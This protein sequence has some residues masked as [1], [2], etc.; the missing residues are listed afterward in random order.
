M[1]LQK[2]R[3][4][5]KGDTIGVVATGRWLNPDRLDQATHFWETRG[6]RVKI[7]PNNYS[8][9]HEW[10]GDFE[11]RATALAD[12]LCDPEI[13]AIF[14][15]G[16]GNRTLHLLDYINFERLKNTP[17]KIIMGFSD[18]TALINAL[19]HKCHWVTFH[20]PSIAGYSKDTAEIH[21]KEVTEILSG[22]SVSHN[23]TH[24]QTLRQG[25]G[26]GPLI[27]G[28]MCIFTYLLGT[29]FISDLKGKILF[30]EDES[31]EIRNIDRMLLH[32]RRLGHMESISGLMI[33]GFSMIG[34]NGSISFPYSLEELLLEHT[35][36]LNI[37]VIMN[38]PFSHS[39]DII[40]L[41]LGIEA[42]LTAGAETSTLK[43]LESAVQ[44]I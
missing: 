32:L 36:G 15:A 42:A 33:G 27:G 28:N 3:A 34:N 35:E 39:K 9:Y 41:P 2:P 17:P 43:L 31:E 13:T 7:H 38:A 6:Y 18:T 44:K 10:G 22:D 37:P 40:P 23:F 12:Y 8:R 29:E 11:E 14:N 25:T 1:I 16:G 5:N 24:A 19:H 21:Y 30:L 26:S 4:L 20:G